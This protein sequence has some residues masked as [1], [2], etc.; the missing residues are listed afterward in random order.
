MNLKRYHSNIVQF[1]GRPCAEQI[2]NALKKIKRSRKRFKVLDL[3]CGDGVIMHS[4]LN[5]KLVSPNSIIGVDNSNIRIESAKN[6]IGNGVKIVNGNAI[7]LP[8]VD[9]SF[10]LVYSLMVMEHLKDDSKYAREIYRVLK[11]KGMTVILTVIKKNWGISWYRKDGKFILDPTH[12][13]EYLGK[14]EL[15]TIFK[16][17]GFKKNQV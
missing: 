16:E 10:D 2:L 14:D 6:L 1:T 4:L 5:Q 12:V 11:P 3:G 8:F 7:N 15:I 17:E 13:R 9:H